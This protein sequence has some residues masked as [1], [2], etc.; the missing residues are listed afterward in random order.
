M[1]NRPVHHDVDNRDTGKFRPHGHA[2]P[3][4]QRYGFRQSDAYRLSD[5]PVERYFARYRDSFRG[6]NHGAQRAGITRR[7]RKW[8]ILPLLALLAGGGVA[9][10]WR[11]APPP[12]AAT[13]VL[14]YGAIDIRQSQ[15]A[16]NDN[17]RI[18]RILVQ[19]SRGRDRACCP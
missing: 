9:A 8:I 18:G 4:R 3:Y 1:D 2:A 19:R 16:F 17:D 10:W 7:R 5:L 6:W 11:L 15:L 12:A 14:A 13:S